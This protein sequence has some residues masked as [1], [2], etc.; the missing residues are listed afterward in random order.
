M[1]KKIKNCHFYD[2]NVLRSRFV[3]VF[4]KKINQNEVIE[5]VIFVNES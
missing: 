5:I 3:K 2:T 4:E 1:F